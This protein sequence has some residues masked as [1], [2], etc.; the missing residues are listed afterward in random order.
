[1]FKLIKFALILF[2]GV[3]SCACVNMVA[4]HELNQKA[5]DYLE[6][7]DL[8]SAISRLEA[9]VDLD[10]NIYESRYNL[11]SAYMQTGEFEKALE[12]I[13]V[14]LK[15]QK[16]EPIVFYTHAVASQ[17][18]SEGIFEKK[19]DDGEIVPVPYHTEEDEKRAATRYVNL[20]KDANK[21]FNRYLELVP[22]A[23]DTQQI[24]ELIKQNEENIAAKTQQYQIVSEE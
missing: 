18:V 9:S 20:L 6:E 14:A 24:Y 15:L 13:Q 12:N 7:G 19:N 8:K 4:V 22:N 11:A 3:I 1:M 2:L 17:R 16:N 10:G 5:N 23:E 21:S